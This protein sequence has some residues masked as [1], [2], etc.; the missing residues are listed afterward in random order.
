MSKKILITGAAGFTGL[1]ITKLATQSGYECVALCHKS[2]DSVF[3]CGKVI[4]ADLT[5]KTELS[6]QLSQIKPDYV[7]HLAAI[8][9]VAH[10]DTSEIYQTN[11]LGTINLMECLAE[12]QSTI[13]KL[14]IV[15]SGNVYGN[16]QNLPIDE[17]M[18]PE[19][20]NDYAISKY[21]MELATKIR[22]DTLPTVIVRPFNYTGLGQAEHFIIPKIIGAFR[23]KD[24]RIE[25]G[26]LDVARDFS[27]VRDVAS[28]YIKLLESEA[29]SEI[30]N[31]CT[32]R[33]IALTTIIETLNSIAGY[34]MEVSI[35][36][37]FVRKNEIKQLFGSN[38]K[39]VNCIGE[40]Q[41]YEFEDTLNWMYQ[42]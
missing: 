15:S 33:A 18:M 25:L 31:V 29:Q 41:N 28:S 9:F 5:N 19:P 6:R 21:S 10:G 20:V 35:N 11:L 8:S 34:K 24:R 4:V 22:F 27:D 37:D 40:Y 17:L 32:G 3:A 7:I 12:M 23:R 38:L 14:L 2:T 26:N 36:P 16:N 30:F 1:H 39:L 13:K 42:G